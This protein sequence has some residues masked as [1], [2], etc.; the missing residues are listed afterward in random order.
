MKTPYD[1]IEDWSP[2]GRAR[3][4]LEQGTYVR[5]LLDEALTV[6]IERKGVS[7]SAFRFHGEDPVTEAVE[8][9]VERFLTADIDPTRLHP[10]SR[11]LKIFTEVGF[12][13]AQRESIRG[14]KRVMAESFAMR[15]LAE[16]TCSG[17]PTDLVDRVER[18]ATR[19]GASLRQLRHRTCEDLVGFWLQGTARLRAKVLGHG[20]DHPNVGV[21]QSPKER[22]F[23]IGDAMF[24]F[25][26]LHLE[27]LSP[28]VDTSRRACALALFTPCSN[29][30]PYR[31]PDQVVAEKLSLRT[32]REASKIWKAGL[33]DFLVKC[34]DLAEMHPDEADEPL[35]VFLG[36]ESLR[37]SLLHLYKLDSA[38]L[39]DRIARIPVGDCS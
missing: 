11:T 28:L 12:W 2:A 20:T 17:E 37:S 14:Y 16:G 23:H 27:M 22:S 39:M 4:I 31:L 26:V 30:P 35:D 13:L 21:G 6:F 10:N 15:N 38:S 29:A 9:C 8:W 32:G 18:W 19:L 33:T 34:L 7:L 3:L 25:L 24:R 5:L 36:R 1:T